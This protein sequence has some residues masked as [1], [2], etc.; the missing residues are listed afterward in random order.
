MKKGLVT[1]TNQDPEVL[2][3]PHG[4]SV[5]GAN[6]KT[7]FNKPLPSQGDVADVTKNMKRFK[8]KKDKHFFLQVG[9]PVPMNAKLVKATKPG[10]KTMMVK[11]IEAGWA[12]V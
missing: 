11:C 8:Q 7:L 12:L 6:R 3:N 10:D 9:M 2:H 5:K 4:Y 1:I